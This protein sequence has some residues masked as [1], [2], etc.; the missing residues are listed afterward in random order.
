MYYK[1]IIIVIQLN[2][3]CMT[4]TQL[5]DITITLLEI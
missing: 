2:I 3:T 1:Y 4:N 5:Y